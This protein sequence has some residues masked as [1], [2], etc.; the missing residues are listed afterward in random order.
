MENFGAS[1]PSVLTQPCLKV[2]ERTTEK[3]LQNSLLDV[4]SRHPCN[5]SRLLE[6]SVEN[7]VCLHHHEVRFVSFDILFVLDVKFGQKARYLLPTVAP[8]IFYL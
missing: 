3:L 4:V 1:S 5:L 2:S 7:F 6:L 8:A